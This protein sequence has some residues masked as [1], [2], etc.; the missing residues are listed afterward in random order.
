[1]ARRF[2][3][4]Q[5]KTP[6]IWKGCLDESRHGSKVRAALL[7]GNT[8][9]LCREGFL[10]PGEEGFRK[11]SVISLVEA[12]FAFE[13]IQKVSLDNIEGLDGN[14]HGIRPGFNKNNIGEMTSSTEEWE[15]FLQ[16]EDEVF[17]N[18]KL[19]GIEGF[20][21]EK[22]LKEP[23]AGEQWRGIDYRRTLLANLKKNALRG[24]PCIKN[25]SQGDRKNRQG[26]PDPEEHPLPVMLL[27]RDVSDSMGL[28]SSGLCLSAFSV[29]KTFLKKKYPQAILVHLVHDVSA[30]E[31][32]PGDFL[33]IA[34]C[35]GTVC[36]S[37]YRL[38]LEILEQRFG[39]RRYCCCL[40]HISDGNNTLTDNLKCRR[41]LKAI[42]PLT[43]LCAYLQVAGEESQA[44]ETLG[45][46]F[47]SM[48]SGTFLN[49]K[50]SSVAEIP[51]VLGRLFS[52]Y[53]LSP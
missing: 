44:P 29:I 52:T 51:Q 33:S 8:E 4:R 42:L 22:H 18:W 16:L 7:S 9:S 6:M 43:V 24:S 2:T 36:S 39:A 38:A 5:T 35:G 34:R 10:V 14:G 3:V 30:R 15:S 53:E 49:T 21:N 11:R 27:I 20:G 41:L 46:V 17:S 48:E 32:G 50:I 19:P 47:R 12:G 37:A 23:L 1:M 45:A 28:D 31:V 25:I 13:T 40:I 26:A